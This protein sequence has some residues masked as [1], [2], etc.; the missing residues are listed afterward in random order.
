M[1][2]NL[3][4]PVIVQADGKVLVEANHKTYEQP[5][6][7]LHSLLNWNPVQMHCIPIRLPVFHY[8][9]LHLQIFPH[10][11]SSLVLTKSVNTPFPGE[12]EELIADTIERYGLVKLVPYPERP[13]EIKL[14]FETPYVQR[15]FTGDPLVQDYLIKRGRRR[16]A[17]LSVS[18]SKIEASSNNNVCWQIG[19]S[20]IL[21]GFKP[22]TALQVNFEIASKIQMLCL[23]LET[24]Q[25]EAARRWYQDGQINRWMWCRRPCLWWWQDHR[26]YHSNVT[27]SAK[28]LILATNQASVNQWIQE[29]ISKTTLTASRCWFLHSR[30]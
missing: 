23:N 7:S 6:S 22:G 18:P 1:Q 17:S 26:W 13:S 3:D 16:D 21:A 25:W 14:E 19:L 12:V 11:R 2:I 24:Y 8:G 4:N 27:G 28:T 10:P 15:L 9:M 5:V 30:F 29:I 20:K